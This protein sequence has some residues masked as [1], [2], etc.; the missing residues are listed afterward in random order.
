MDEYQDINAGQRRLL[1]LLSA[2]SPNG[3]FLIGD[4]AQSIYSYRG[5]GTRFILSVDADFPGITVHRLAVSRRCHRNILQAAAKVLTTHSDFHDD[6]SSVQYV[7]RAATLGPAPFVWQFYSMQLEAEAVASVAAEFRSQNKKVLVLVP[8]RELYL[9]VSQAMDKHGVPYSGPAPAVSFD[10]SARLSSAAKFVRWLAE[11]TNSFAARVAMEE[12]LDQGSCRVEGGDRRHPCST[13]TRETRLN[14]ER[15]IALLWGQV[16][17]G[18]R[19]LYGAAKLTRTPPATLAA[20]VEVMK[21]LESA[22]SGEDA[23]KPGEL[24]TRLVGR[25]ALW[26][27]PKEFTTDIKALWQATRP[28]RLMASHRVL[29]TTTKKAKGLEAD[30]VIIPG[31]EQGIIPDTS[32]RALP[33]EEARL[34]YVSMTR[35]REKLFLFHSLRRPGTQSRQAIHESRPRSPYL[36][37][38]GIGSTDMNPASIEAA[39]TMFRAERGARPT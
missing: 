16:K 33:D 22:Y 14:A 39:M 15:S 21:Q 13:A 36:N 5:G 34:F 23:D 31:V 27:N 11:P 9:P 4:E 32:P 17:F 38:M 29:L 37:T 20:I 35:A 30:V 12:L 19:T 3:V 26:D 8:R 7:G 2:H 18:T 10:T 25:A 24:I 28:E 6:P 1:Q